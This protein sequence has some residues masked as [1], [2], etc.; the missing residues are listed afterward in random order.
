MT[1]QVRRAPVQGSYLIPRGEPGHRPGTVTWAEH[2]EAYE[3]YAKRYGRSQSAERLAERAGFG[4]GEL[5]D[6]LGRAPRT[7]EPCE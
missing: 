3:D 6:H 2:L 1:H 7:W 4:Y 5:V